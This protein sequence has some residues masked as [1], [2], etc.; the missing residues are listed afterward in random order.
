MEIFKFSVPVRVTALC[1]LLTACDNSS[2]NNKT[3]AKEI[4]GEQLFNDVSLSKDGTQ[5]CATCHHSEHA[6]IDARLNS[7]SID[8]NTAGAVST[9]QDDLA[10]G[11]INTPSAAYTAFVPKFHFDSTEGLFKGGLF[12]DGRAVDLVEQA[13]QPFLNP[14]EMQSTKQDVVAKVKE[15]Y[16]EALIA[17]YGAAI[18]IDIDTAFGAIADSIATFEKT[19]AS[20]DSRFDKVLRGDV[21]FT[22]QESLGLALFV[23]ENKAN[24]AACHPVPQRQ[25]SK[26]ESL[27]TDFSYDNLGVPKN[28]LVR[29]LNGKAPDFVD[30]GLFNNVVVDDAEL[31]GAFRVAG[32]RNVAVTA[33]Y[34]HNG[35]F[36]DLK[37]VVQFYNS[38]DVIGAVN[39]ETGTGW[40]AAEVG[41]TK[42]TDE[43]GNLGLSD[44]EVDAI[45][46]FLKTLTDEQYQHLIP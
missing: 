17:L 20:F 29:A 41:E 1:F 25:S 35:V 9:G 45:V 42:N 36:S 31:K 32:L 14:L 3:Q 16:S 44:A 27:F 8:A 6:F 2:N 23:A 34:M 18:F 5:S 19:L 37:T 13:K 33:P 22:M 24:C 11:D 43:L 38:R 15:K 12:L 26:Q 10:L 40:M 46:A 7:T 4:L 21:E 30:N 39:P 28:A